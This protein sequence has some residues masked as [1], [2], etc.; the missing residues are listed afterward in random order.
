MDLK[1]RNIECE[2]NKNKCS[3]ADFSILIYL[4]HII[5]NL[6]NKSRTLIQEPSP[7]P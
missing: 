1:V 2:R 7:L 4:S 6:K 5:Y 3:S